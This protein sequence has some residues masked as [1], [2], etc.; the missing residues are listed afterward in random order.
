MAALCV[1]C[2]SNSGHDAAFADAARALGTEIAAAGHT[3]VYGGGHVGLM[4]AVADAALANG[5]AVVGVMTEQLVGAEVAHQGLT[6]LEVVSS[7]HERKARMAELADGV[8]VLPGGFGTLDETFEIMTWNQLGLVAVPVVF[9]DVA[10]YFD[11]LF[12]FVAS[13]VRAGFV[14]D[15]HAVLAR[16]AADATAAIAAATRLAQDFSPKW[17]A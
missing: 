9:L 4:G 7:M 17:L 3:L 5:G 2:G 6:R 11:E 16:R 12:A 14:S 15:A 10:G 13:S 8:V 1:F